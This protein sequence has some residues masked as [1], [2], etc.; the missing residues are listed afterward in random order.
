LVRHHDVDGFVRQDLDALAS[1]C[2]AEDPVLEAEQLLDGVHDLR[3]VVHHQHA[4]PPRL[5]RASTFELRGFDSPMPSVSRPTPP[6][7]SYSAILS[8][9]QLV[10][11]GAGGSCRRGLRCSP[12]EEAV[13]CEAEGDREE[14]RRGAVEQTALTRLQRLIDTVASRLWP[15]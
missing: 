12:G 11:S 8:G 1:P 4:V 15:K 7:F 14:G 10:N 13:G 2:G 5:H 3:F 6:D 9:T